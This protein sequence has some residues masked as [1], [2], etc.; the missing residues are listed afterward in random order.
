MKSV[1]SLYTLVAAA[2][3]HYTFDVL[4]V[5]GQESAGWQYIR[6]NTREEKYM[7]T[8]FIHSFGTT[9]LDDDFRCNQG[10][11]SNAGKTQVATV[12]PGSS[13]SMKAAYG[14]RIQHPVSS[15][16]E[17]FLHVHP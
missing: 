3:A 1:I 12:A 17:P 11:N 10:A 4:V 8:K 15:P 16:C 5:D 2:T 6:E 9:P 7:P 13:L 14:A